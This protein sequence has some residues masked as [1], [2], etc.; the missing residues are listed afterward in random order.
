MELSKSKRDTKKTWFWGHICFQFSTVG[1]LIRNYLLMEST[2]YP[3]TTEILTGQL[4]LDC[5]WWNHSLFLVL[6]NYNAWCWELSLF[7]LFI[8]LHE[9]LDSSWNTCFTCM[10]KPATTEETLLWTFKEHIWEVAS[11]GLTRYSCACLLTRKLLLYKTQH[12]LC[13]NGTIFPCL[14]R[15]AHTHCPPL[16]TNVNVTLAF[17]YPDPHP[18]SAFLC[19]ARLPHIFPDSLKAH[20]SEGASIHQSPFCQV[21][22]YWQTFLPITQRS[23]L[24]QELSKVWCLI[25]PC[26]E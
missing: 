18:A 20:I 21:N 3:V 24:L 8:S 22:H 1:I 11:V 15:S 2:T 26:L 16:T 9:N 7:G 12:N 25:F 17:T 10:V 6:H 23:A 19:S 5:I 13:S 4:A 14:Q